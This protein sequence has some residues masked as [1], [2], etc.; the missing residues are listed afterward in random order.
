[1]TL[2]RRPFIRFFACKDDF[3]LEPADTLL[4]E[5][6]R[7]GKEPFLVIGAMAGG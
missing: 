3:S 6:V 4:P 1:V 5:E 2:K 7:S